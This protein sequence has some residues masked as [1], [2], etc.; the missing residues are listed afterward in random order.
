M[1][2]KMYVKVNLFIQ[3]HNEIIYIYKKVFI[4]CRIF[5]ECMTIIEILLYKGLM[6]VNVNTIIF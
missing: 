3:T 5:K 1:I 4:Y 6:A 2:L